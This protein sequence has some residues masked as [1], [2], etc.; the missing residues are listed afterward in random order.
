MNVSELGPSLR[1]AV[2]LWRS[3]LPRVWGALLLLTA[4]SLLGI[5]EGAA[6]IGPGWV[7]FTSVLE[8][9]ATVVAFGALFRLAL[10]DSASG[11]P[12]PLGLQWTRVEFRM[13]GA[14]ALTFFLVLLI[15]LAVVFAVLVLIAVLY[16]GMGA[17]G[18]PNNFASS[19]AGRASLWIGGLGALVLLYVL[20]RLSLSLPATVARGVIQVF[21]VWSSSRGRVVPLLVVAILFGLPMFLRL[22][23]P[24]LIPMAIAGMIERSNGIT[25]LTIGLRVLAGVLGGFVQLPMLAGALAY[26]YPRAVEATAEP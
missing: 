2:A 18:V 19:P 4:V 21:S 20:I 15:A 14:F 12:G 25:S 26:L 11:A 7:L 5:W 1:A 16:I 9:L 24:M 6:G 13:L 8:I 17:G 23:L 22:G 10:P 3:A